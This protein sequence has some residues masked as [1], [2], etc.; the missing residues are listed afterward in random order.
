VLF[1]DR[2]QEPRRIEIAPA[3]SALPMEPGWH[4]MP[5]TGRTRE[6]RR[7][8]P[9]EAAISFTIRGSVFNEKRSEEETLEVFRGVRLREASEPQSELKRLR[10]ERFVDRSSR[11]WKERVW[12]R[13]SRSGK[14][15]RTCER[16][17]VRGICRRHT[18]APE[19]NHRDLANRLINSSADGT[20]GGKGGRKS[21]CSAR[22][23]RWCFASVLSTKAAVRRIGRVWHLRPFA[24]TITLR[25]L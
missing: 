15:G 11:E 25:A 9:A 20:P 1:R 16:G 19:R 12:R 13:L 8:L 14:K 4:Q 24:S 6:K 7:V 22:R 5:G 23:A 18:P 10:E 2:P 17:A 21:K 3:S